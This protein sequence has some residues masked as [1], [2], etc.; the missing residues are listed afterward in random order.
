MACKPVRATALKWHKIL[1]YTGPDA[2]KQLPKY[3][4][5]VKLTE[6]TTE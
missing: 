3:T 1:G 5:S 4:N 2:I 6:L